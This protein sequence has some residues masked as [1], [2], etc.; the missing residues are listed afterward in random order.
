MKTY[1]II[2][3]FFSVISAQV[4]SPCEDK[5]FLKISEKFIDQMT[6]E[7]YQYFIS[8][9]NECSEY[10]NKSV[11]SNANIESSLKVGDSIAQQNPCED[12]Q[13]IKISEKYV[14]MM[15]ENEYRYFLVKQKEC[16]MF[17]KDNPILKQLRKR[18]LKAGKV[19]S[20]ENLSFIYQPSNLLGIVLLLVIFSII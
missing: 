4:T 12:E 9:E 13:F 6:D 19:N 8:K 18:P 14:D 7:E 3:Y 5:K 16:A 10:Q 11:A 1:I 2:F 20:I 17:D 15:T